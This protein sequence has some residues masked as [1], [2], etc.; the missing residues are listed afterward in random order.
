MYTIK[1]KSEQLCPETSEI[2]NDCRVTL[3]DVKSAFIGLK[4]GNGNYALAKA[5]RPPISPFGFQF[6]FLF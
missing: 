3:N 5:L 4:P 2:I 1:F 6:F